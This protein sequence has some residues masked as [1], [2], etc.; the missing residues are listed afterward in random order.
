[1]SVV[2]TVEGFDGVEK[3]SIVG[4]MDE[5]GVVLDCD[6]FTDEPLAVAS[7]ANPDMRAFGVGCMGHRDYSL[8]PVCDAKD[9]EDESGEADD[10]YGKMTELCEFVGVHQL[11]PS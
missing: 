5:T 8:H 11:L 10:L 7:T 9:Y 4:T 6:D 3:D 1:V 2:V